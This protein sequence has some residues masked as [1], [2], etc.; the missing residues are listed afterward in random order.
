[1]VGNKAHAYRLGVAFFSFLTPLTLHKDDVNSGRH[2][3]PCMDGTIS[4][5]PQTPCCTCVLATPPPRPRFESGSAV[6]KRLN[7]LYNNWDSFR[8]TVKML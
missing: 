3:A 2:T 1:M 5:Q 8:D 4:P 6:I 7:I